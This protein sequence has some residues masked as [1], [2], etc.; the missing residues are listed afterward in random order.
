MNI[1]LLKWNWYFDIPY[2]ISYISLLLYYTRNSTESSQS[3]L[4]DPHLRKS[5]EYPGLLTHS[6]FKTPLS[7][8]I[9]LTTN[10]KT[11]WFIYK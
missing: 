9:V 10:Y 11:H 6:S 8:F 3:L 2:N 4:F 7:S 1:C 5:S